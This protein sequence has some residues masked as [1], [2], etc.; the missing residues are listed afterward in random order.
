M[1]M[2]MTM[3]VN[4]DNNNYNLIHHFY[5]ES[6]G[7][8]PTMFVYKNRYYFHHSPSLDGGGFKCHGY[9]NPDEIIYKPATQQQLKQLYDIHFLLLVLLK[10]ISVA[11]FFFFYRTSNIS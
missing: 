5:S 2:T 8:V 1:T 11:V 4:N 10:H 3:V 7:C 9:E 6:V